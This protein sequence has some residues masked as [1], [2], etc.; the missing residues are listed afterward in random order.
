MKCK[1]ED[2]QVLLMFMLAHTQ[3]VTLAITHLVKI[4]CENNFE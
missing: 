1:Q 4:G 2:F 3:N